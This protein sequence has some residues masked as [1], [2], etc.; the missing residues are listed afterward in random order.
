[1]SPPAVYTTPVVST[2]QEGNSYLA[3]LGTFESTSGLDTYILGDSLQ[4]KAST[5]AYPVLSDNMQ[6]EQKFNSLARKWNRETINLSSIQ[7]MVLH[8]AYQEIIAMGHKVVP[9]ILNQLK[10]KPDFWF[11][12]LRSL[13]GANPVTEEIRGDVIAMTKAWLDWGREHA[14]L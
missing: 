2:S 10:K 14:Y 5:W 7:Q 13:T 12:A 8:P 1:M 4:L 6:L 11:W 3:D 9:L